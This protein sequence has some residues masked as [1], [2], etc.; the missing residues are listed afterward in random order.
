MSKPSTSTDT[1][2][3]GVRLRSMLV[4]TDSLT[5]HVP[6]IEALRPR[7]IRSWW[8]SSTSPPPS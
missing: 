2:D 1:D 7:M 6:G 8:R 4:A 5:L 3:A